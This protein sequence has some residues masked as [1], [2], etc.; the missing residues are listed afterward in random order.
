MVTNKAFK[1]TQGW[2]A[3]WPAIAVLI[4]AIIAWELSVRF[5]NVP[6]YL[7]PAPTQIAQYIF[8]NRGTFA[9]NL[10]AT[11]RLIAFSYLISVAMGTLL[12]IVLG[13][14]RLFGRAIYPLLVAS[15]TFP[16]LAVGPLFIVWFGFGDTPKLL[17]AF[18]VAFFPVM[19]N[20]VLGLKAVRGDTI[21]LAQVLGL[22]R[23]QT[24]FKVQAPQA[25][26]SVFGGLK[27]AA[28]LAVIGVIVS[29]FLGASAGLGYLIITATGSMNSLLLFSALVLTAAMGMSL[30]AIIVLLESYFLGPRQ[31]AAF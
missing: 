8:L 15:Q 11:L 13:R 4:L 23:L 30:Y 20:T 14:S 19:I 31:K 16:K 17:L 10:L 6:L 27:I 18:L 3:Y 7:L 24:F 21:M 5:L 2:T 28:T 22:S 29:E 12:G 9:T 25:L 26:P 1:L